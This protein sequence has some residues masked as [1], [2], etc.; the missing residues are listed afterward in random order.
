MYLDAQLDR[1]IDADTGQLCLS[2]EVQEINLC[3]LENYF[4]IQCFQDFQAIW[5]PVYQSI[6]WKTISCNTWN[7]ISTQNTRLKGGLTLNTDWGN[8]WA[9]IKL[10]TFYTR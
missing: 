9:L 8:G 10:F 6:V 1:K 3:T 2:L 7:C 4:P 5:K